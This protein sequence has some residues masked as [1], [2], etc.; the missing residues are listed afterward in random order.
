LAAEHSA[1]RWIQTGRGLGITK[2]PVV[3]IALVGKKGSTYH[4]L[5]PNSPVCN[6]RGVVRC[7]ELDVDPKTVSFD[8]KTVC[9]R[10]IK[11]LGPIP[12]PALTQEPLNG[13]NQ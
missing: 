1:I 7:V 5:D 8:G 12:M 2:V 9:G 4:I 6:T 13:R 10:C 11:A 3:T